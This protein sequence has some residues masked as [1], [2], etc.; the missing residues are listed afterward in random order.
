[1]ALTGVVPLWQNIMRLHA[2][3]QRTFRRMTTSVTSDVSNGCE[4]LV[5]CANVGCG[6][7]PRTNAMRGQPAARRPPEPRNGN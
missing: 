5:L 3:H 7:F 2:A 1:M 6:S 4:N